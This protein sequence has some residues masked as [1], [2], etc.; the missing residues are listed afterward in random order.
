M[1]RNAGK[2]HDRLRD[3]MNNDYA[4]ENDQYPNTRQ[5]CA[6]L[7]QKY[8]K[9]RVSARVTEEYGNSFIQTD[10]GGRG[11]RGGR[12][13]RSNL[14][15]NLHYNK[16]DLKDKTCHGCG[17]KGSPKWACQKQSSGEK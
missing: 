17:R 6:Y 3:D 12:G 1:V 5:Q 15:G 8:S 4:K 16:Q 14:S 9:N 13:D 11:G 2:E 7:L 10:H